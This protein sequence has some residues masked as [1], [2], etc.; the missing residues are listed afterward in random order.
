M[1]KKS[2]LPIGYGTEGGARGAVSVET[3]P[4]A[5]P[6]GVNLDGSEGTEGMGGGHEKAGKEMGRMTHGV[7]SAK[8]GWY[9][10]IAE[11]CDYRGRDKG[12][13]MRHASHKNKHGV[14]STTGKASTTADSS[15]PANGSSGA[16]GIGRA[17]FMK[18]RPAFSR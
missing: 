17:S 6:M 7:G 14:G 18:D 4:C 10:C 13:G 1:D 2:G 3:L 11:G 9:H 8:G 15:T 16:H 5:F 12:H